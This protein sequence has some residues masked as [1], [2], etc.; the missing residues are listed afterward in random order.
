MSVCVARHVLSG[1]YLLSREQQLSQ[2]SYLVEV[3]IS[4]TRCVD[5]RGEILPEHIATP[6]IIEALLI[7][8]EGRRDI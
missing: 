2:K 7:S 3:H 6:R 4:R 1:Y 5:N 8:E